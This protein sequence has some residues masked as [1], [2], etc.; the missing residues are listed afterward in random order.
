MYTLRKLYTYFL[1]A[2]LF[3]FFTGLALLDESATPTT[4]NNHPLPTVDV[5]SYIG[6]IAISL[7]DAPMPGTILYSGMEKSK[8][9]LQALEKSSCP[10]IG[11]FAT[12]AH[13]QGKRNIKR[14]RMY[15]EAGHMIA[16]HSYNH[17]NLN[18]VTAEKFIAD[19]KKAHLVL[20]SLPNFK[21]FFRFPYLAEG[22]NKAQRQAVISALQAMGYQ[23]GYTTVNNHDYYINKLLVEAIKAGKVVDYDKLR[24]LYLSILWDCIE[25]S[26]KLA[27]KVLHRKVK[28]VL[29]LHENDLAALFIGDLIT[30]IRNQGWRI[31]SIEEAYQDPIARIPITNTSSLVG[32]I[33]AIAVEQGLG[34]NLVPFPPT[35]YLEYIPKAIKEQHIFTTPNRTA[36]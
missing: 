22:K 19:I 24:D 17:Y 5:S 34:K 10:A 4:N 16:N 1:V 12:A 11:V 33:S 31:I 3:I 27:Y 18:K 28:H 7:D 26:Q 8:K 32:R 15:G 20:S 25:T 30:H 14:L 36:K 9:I 29:L 35:T 6:E 2:F 21:P 13:A 23:E